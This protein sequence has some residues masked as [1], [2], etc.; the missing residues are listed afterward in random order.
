[1]YDMADVCAISKAKARHEDLKS[2]CLLWIYR[3]GAKFSSKL[4]QNLFFFSLKSPLFLSR[5]S[6]N[7]FNV[8]C[9]R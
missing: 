3:Y 7:P 9:N 4:L 6:G 8:K 5:K 1:M 2:P